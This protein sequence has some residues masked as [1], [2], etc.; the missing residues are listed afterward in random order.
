MAYAGYSIKDLYPDYANVLSTNDGTSLAEDIKSVYV[1]MDSDS[2]MLM[3]KNDKN[4]TILAIIAV[5]AVLF[6]FG[7]IK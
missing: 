2:P 5:I 7:L 1:Q 3:T 4:H 6:M